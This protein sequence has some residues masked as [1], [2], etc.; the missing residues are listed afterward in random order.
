[1]SYRR[2]SYINLMGRRHLYD[3]EKRIS[4]LSVTVEHPPMALVPANSAY[5]HPGEKYDHTLRRNPLSIQS[6][7]L[8]SSVDDFVGKTD[9]YLDARWFVAIPNNV[10]EKKNA[11]KT[12]WYNRWLHRPGD[13]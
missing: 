12:S 5:F 10:C 6:T 2:E 13:I 11:R 1:M 7:Y 8:P 4:R 3:E 9:Q